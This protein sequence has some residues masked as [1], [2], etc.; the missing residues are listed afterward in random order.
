VRWLRAHVVLLRGP[1]GRV[2]GTMGTTEDVTERRAAAETAERARAMAD[3]ERAR[4]DAVLEALPAGIIFA[5]ADGRIVRTTRQARALWGGDVTAAGVEDY[6]SYRARVRGSD[7]ALTDEERGLARALRGESTSPRE[8]EI[9]RLDGGTATV[10]SAAAPVR[11]ADGNIVGGVV[12]LIDISE[13]VQLE[14]QLRQAQKMEAVGQLAGGVAHDFNNL[15]TVINGNLEFARD[16]LGADHP[17]QEDLAQ[18]AQ[19]AERARALV[20]QLLAFSRKQVV[21]PKDVDVN[22]IVRGADALLKRVLGDEIVYVASL[23]PEAAVVRADRGQIEQV[24]LNLAVNARDA[25]LTSG[26]GLPG[27]GGTLT[28]TTDVVR[29]TTGDAGGWAPLAPG[30]YVR[31]RVADTGHGMDATTLAHIFEPFFTTKAVG[32][33][34]GL[35]LATVYGIVAQAGGAVRVESAPGAGA[36]FTILLPHHGTAA[37]EAERGGGRALPRGRG[38]VLVVEDEASVRIATRRLL[39]RHGYAVLEARHGADA[40][41]VWREHGPTIVACVTDLRMPEMGGR[42]LVAQL[43]AD[44]ADLPVVYLSGYADRDVADSRDG[45][46]EKPFT[47]EALLAALHTAIGQEGRRAGGQERR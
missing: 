4:L 14:A 8:L 13:R 36:T 19:A 31:I 30:R 46:V 10:L 12:A 41:L 15:L 22:E 42:E 39:E 34:T 43:R 23:A 28:V 29:L 5:D 7:R 20:R 38:T 37:E 47:G 3:V 18:V 25:M 2:V 33:G 32:V 17:V 44:R 24:L 26:H 6:D 11:D 21:Q 40:I 16:D 1:S 35:G 45:F 27:T 9:E